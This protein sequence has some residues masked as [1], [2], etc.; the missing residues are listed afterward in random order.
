MGKYEMYRC[1]RCGKEWEASDKTEAPVA[2]AIIVQFGQ[3]GIFLPSRTIPQQNTQMWCRTCALK[4]GMAVAHT[5][6]E[7]QIA[8]PRTLT[9]EERAI[10]LIEE[11]GF[12]RGGEYE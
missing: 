11:L 1:D 12:V 10:R 2:I 3:S 6:T 9:F 8:T 5:P 7:K 4:T